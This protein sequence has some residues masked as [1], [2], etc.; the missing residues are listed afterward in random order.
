MCCGRCLLLQF[1]LALANAV[2]RIGSL[3]AVAESV[4]VAV[5]D[6]NNR[7]AAAQ[8]LLVLQKQVHVAAGNFAAV[9]T[10]S[11]FKMATAAEKLLR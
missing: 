11:L 2:H 5:A 7:S 6:F 1:V 8:T 4:G 3:R 9:A 10:V